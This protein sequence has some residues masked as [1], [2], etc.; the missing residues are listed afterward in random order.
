MKK[1]GNLKIGRLGEKVALLTRREQKKKKRKS[2]RKRKN[3][4]L[5]WTYPTR[6]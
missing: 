3:I 1:M 6:V 4:D 5:P 2:K